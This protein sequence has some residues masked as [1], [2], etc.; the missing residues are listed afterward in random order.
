MASI[1]GSEVLYQSI[2]GFKREIKPVFQG[3]IDR[4][5]GIIAR[6][7]DR[8]GT[9]PLN[10]LRDV[11]TEAGAAVDSMFVGVDGRSAYAPDEV[12]PLAPYP[13]VLNKW[14]VLASWG[15][16]EAHQ[17]YIR[18]H[19][20]DTLFSWL[21]R[22]QGI[23]PGYSA[24]HEWVDPNGYRL[25][26]RIWRAD[27][28]T[29]LKIDSLLADGIRQGKSAASIARQLEQFLLPGRQ[30]IKS[31]KVASGSYDAMRLARTEITRAF[32]EATIAAAQANPFVSG[33][34]W[35]L[36]ASHPRVD[37]CD[38]LATVGMSGQRL[39][40]PYPV[41]SVP[42]YPPHPQC[43]CNLRPAVTDDPAAVIAQL[44]REATNGNPAYM[45]PASGQAFLMA[46]MGAALVNQVVQ[47]LRAA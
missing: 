6:N 18:S 8:A 31:R 15:V 19:T 34:D 36:S 22:G 17:R 9:V 13:R 21:T 7:A 16:V 27:M 35:V 29:R 47:E 30:G 39:R 11:Q 38:Q 25:S 14:L 10:R 41:G 40:E 45:T 37:I 5:G 12:T 43:L 26:D 44:E 4:I 28:S 24:A 33:I 46:L 42:G 20:P 1:P 32:G 2:T 23:Q 3:V